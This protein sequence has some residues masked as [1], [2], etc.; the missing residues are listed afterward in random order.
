VKFKLSNEAKTGIIVVVSIAILIWGINFLKGK[1]VFTRETRLYAIYPRVDGLIPSNN[2]LLNGL[3]I[4]T[5]RYLNIIPDN[6]G[7]IL[8]TLHI[9]EDVTIP[10]KS[11]AQIYN[12][13][14]L[15]AKSVRIIL[16]KETEPAKDG[17]TLIAGIQTSFAED[18][19][20]QVAPIKEKAET[21]LSSMD[22]VLVIFQAVFNES[23]RENLKK[24]FES[25]SKSLRSI[26]GISSNLD[27]LFNTQQNNIGA[28]IKNL[29]SI[30][31]NINKNNDK[32][33]SAINNFSAISDTLAKANLA[34]TLAATKK[35]LEQTASVLTKINRGEGSLGLLANND[36]LYNNLNN[37][38]QSLD[39][40]LKDLKAN[41][42][43]YINFSI[44]DFGGSGKTKT[45]EPKK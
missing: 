45:T 24:S 8:V 9:S 22:S 3:K 31:D 5:V 33:S 6:S 17:D 23:T 38:S 39:A 32:I 37:A 11:T 40:L 25:I 21:L 44:I 10:K 15:G 42:K 19:N 27:T 28:I 18:I 1:D 41:P 30:T 13:D 36:S 43:R 20:T 29:R 16:G 12:T 26:E 14:L 4:G 7:R 35:S 2:V 34:A